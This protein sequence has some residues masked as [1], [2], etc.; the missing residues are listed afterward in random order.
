MAVHPQKIGKYTVSGVLGKGAM[1]L[2]YRAQDP[3]LGRDV[4]IK[5]ITGD[6]VDDDMKERFRIEARAA[7]ALDHPNIVVVYD[8]GEESGTPYIAMEL[9]KGE[10]LRQLMRARPDLPVTECCEIIAQVCDGLAYAHQRR[11]IHRDIKPANV[12][13]CPD[14]RVKIVDFGVAKM[15]ST[16]LTAT[17]MVIGT[18]DYMSP[19]QIQGKAVDT[20]SDIFA[21]GVLF[22]ELLARDKP[23]AAESI[24]SVI[25]NIVFKQPRTFA[26]MQR[27]VPA[28]IERI[29]RKAMAKEVS[30]RYQ[31]IGDMAA[32]IRRHLANRS[33]SASEP[34]AHAPEEA[35]RVL[36]AAEA[37]ESAHAVSRTLQVAEGPGQ[38]RAAAEEGR[39]LAM[40]SRD[41][42]A[43]RRGR[44]IALGVAAAVM[45]VAAGLIAA[46]FMSRAEEPA[47]A[48]VAAAALVPVEILVVPWARVVRLVPDGGGPPIVPA[49]GLTP[50]R[51]D[52]APG[53]YRVEIEHPSLE[54]PTSFPVV[55][56]GNGPVRATHVLAGF[57]P[58]A[59][60]AEVI[61]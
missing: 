33:P 20:R 49:Q 42:S 55:V 60:F 50:L 4:A 35:T 12:H 6:E 8:L 45:L 16:S 56:S 11:I 39:T 5:V 1:G 24:T 47:A 21:V 13:I 14:G 61:P 44:V 31:K 22:Y 36:S 57:D 17:G 29:I 25:Y 38:R 30:D 32:D 7:A 18:P 54:G 9:L 28:E 37:A 59:A 53:A 52:V 41:R 19:E 43:P 2:V 34:A 27:E 10:D 15:E 58:E 26:E 48:P 40:G 3:L 51:L 46:R 23:F